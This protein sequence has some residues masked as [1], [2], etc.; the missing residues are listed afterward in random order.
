[1]AV[2]DHHIR[3]LIQGLPS[4]L[5]AI[6]LQHLIIDCQQ[7]S[8]LSQPSGH[9]PRYE[10]AWDLLE[11]VWRHPHA[12]SISDVKAQRFV[13]AVAIQSDTAVRFR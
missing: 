2:G 13:R 6:H 10:D 7:P 12:G 11:P 9:Q 8:A 3:Y 5:N 1:M 4:N